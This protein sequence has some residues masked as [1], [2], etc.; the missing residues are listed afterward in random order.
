MSNRSSSLRHIPRFQ[1]IVSK[2]MR[3]LVVGDST[4]ARNASVE[5]LDMAGFDVTATDVASSLANLQVQSYEI[6]LLDI[7]I[8]KPEG[9]AENPGLSVLREAARREPRPCLVVFTAMSTSADARTALDLGAVAVLDKL[10][11]GD[12]LAELVFEAWL[13]R[14]SSRHA[15]NLSVNIEPE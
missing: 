7:D 9:V 6:L 10:A 15:S 5:Q 2:P 3:V 13:H 1:K 12:N 8:P 4:A 14:K 11:S